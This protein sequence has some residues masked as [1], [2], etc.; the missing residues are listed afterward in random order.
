MLGENAAQATQ[1]VQTGD[2]DAGIIPLSLAI[3]M[4]DRIRY[5]LIDQSLH[6]PLR[7]TAAVLKQSK[8]A[9]V[10][11]AF[12]SFVNGPAGRAIMREYG[13]VLPGERAP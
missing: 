9:D 10:A 1:Y 4:G 12:L 2:A 13:F 3:Q 5:V 11:E 6:E 7:Q 8:H